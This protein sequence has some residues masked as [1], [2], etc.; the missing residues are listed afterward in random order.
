MFELLHRLA[1]W[2]IQ[3]SDS[4]WAVF[5]LGLNS[6]TESIFFPIPPDPLLIALSIGEPRAALWLASLVTIS[7]VSGGLVGH[8]LGRHLGRTMLHRW[9]SESKI[10]TGQQL[11]HKYGAWAI[12]IAAITPIPYKVF[13]VLAGVL[14]MSAGTFFIASLLGRGI[15]FLTIGALFFLYGESIKQYID[16]N[17]QVLTIA[18]GVA[19]VLTA[20][21]IYV[22]KQIR[23]RQTTH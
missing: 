8:W 6:F 22:Y 19:I 9:L 20:L 17:F 12:I 5:F 4:N 18:A 14:N 13:T 10:A 2:T 11:V 23:I 21:L 16:K 15:R 7:S 3:L 1:N